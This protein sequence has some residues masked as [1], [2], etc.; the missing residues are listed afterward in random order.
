MEKF[1][2]LVK[3]VVQYEDKY[4]VVHK[5]YDDRVS[6]P[7]QWEFID[8]VIE[9]GEGPDKAVLRSIFEQTGLSATID[10]ILYTW[11]FMTGDVFNIGISYLCRVSFD[12]V[13]LSEDLV[14][15][16]WIMKFEMENY[17]NSKVLEDVEQA[18]L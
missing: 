3:G 10:R 18:E 17:V 16:R 7:Y 9:F 13:I 15:S 14:D 4:L 6:E 12:D 2:I 8:G 11:S 5:W 1:R